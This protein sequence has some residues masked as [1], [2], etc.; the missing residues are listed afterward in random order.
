MGFLQ[1]LYDDCDKLRQTVIRLATESE[2][3]DSSLG[4]LYMHVYKK[5]NPNKIHSDKFIAVGKV[6]VKCK[7][8][9]LESI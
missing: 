8:D 5:K 7:C 9:I 1:E 2:D 6:C 4:E 3:N